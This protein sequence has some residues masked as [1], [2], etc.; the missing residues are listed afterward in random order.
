MVFS[1]IIHRTMFSF[2]NQSILI[3][4]RTFIRRK[5]ILQGCNKDGTGLLGREKSKR[6]VTIPGKSKPGRHFLFKKN[7]S[8]S[9][10]VF[11]TFF[12]IFVALAEKVLV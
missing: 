2:T 5:I 10:R 12:Q 8:P 7:M 4:H 6:S 1:E 9:T 11:A 3:L